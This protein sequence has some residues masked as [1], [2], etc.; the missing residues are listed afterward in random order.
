MGILPANM[1][2][3][4]MHTHVSVEIRRGYWIPGAGVTDSCE[5]LCGCWELNLGPLQKQPVLST[6]EPALQPRFPA[7]EMCVSRPCLCAED[8]G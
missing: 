4:H 7:L 8:G 2:V 3:H 1:S 6:P 5:L